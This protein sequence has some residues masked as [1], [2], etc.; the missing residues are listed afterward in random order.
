MRFFFLRFLSN[1]PYRLNY[2]SQKYEDISTKIN[3]SKYLF[4]F[5][6]QKACKYFKQCFT[7][8]ACFEHDSKWLYLISIG[9]F[10]GKDHDCQSFPYC[11]YSSEIHS[12]FLWYNSS[13][14]LIWSDFAQCFRTVNL[15]LSVILPLPLPHSFSHCC[16]KRTNKTGLKAD[17]E[18]ARQA[19]LG[20]CVWGGTDKN[21]LFTRATFVSS[22]RYCL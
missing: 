13:L 10:M 1:I 11:M 16:K 15:A 22:F 2:F 17:T 14:F 12:V 7:T 4:G 8:F 19:K 5:K 20:G 6:T 3:C 18:Y 21:S 9:V